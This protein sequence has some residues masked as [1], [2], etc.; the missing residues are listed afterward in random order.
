MH[1]EVQE[2]PEK[3]ASFRTLGSKRGRAEQGVSRDQ[4][5]VGGLVVVGIDA[6]VVG[7][8]R[9]DLAAFKCERG[10]EAGFEV[11][12]GLAKDEVAAGIVPA[13]IDPEEPVVG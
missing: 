9:V 12:V 10:L 1:E 2:E 3:V 4:Q 7:D 11:T 6:D 13:R 8:R 5:L